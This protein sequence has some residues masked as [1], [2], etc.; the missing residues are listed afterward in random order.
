[1]SSQPFSALCGRPQSV[2]LSHMS[3][4]ARTWLIVVAGALL[5]TWVGIGVV[6]W[7]RGVL[8]DGHA[9]SAAG[10]PQEDH[11]PKPDKPSAPPWGK[12]ERIPITIAPPIEFVPEFTPLEKFEI[13][14]YFPN[15]SGSRLAELLAESGISEEVR[16][17]LMSMAALEPSISGY[18]IRP[19]EEFVYQL[20]RQDRARL[21]VLLAQFAENFYHVKAFRFCGKSL[22]DWL[23]GAPLSEETIALVRPLVFQHEGYLFFA[24][25]RVIEKRISS[26]DERLALIKALSRE[27]TFLARLRVD[28]NSDIE[29]LVNY[30]GRGG[31][32]KDVRP[33]L[34]SAASVPGGVSLAISHLLPPF[35]RQRL[36]TYPVP[37]ERAPAINQDCHW[38]AFNFFNTEP[39]NRFCDENEVVKALD[40]EYYRVFGN[41]QLGDIVMFFIEGNRVIHSAVYIADDI[42][43]TKNGS[44]ASRPWMLT[45]LE[46]MKGYY[47]TLKPKEIR[48]YRK[49]N[50]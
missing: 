29:G 5:A 26:A 48:Y 25:L 42:L 10:V 36:Y 24:D 39:D 20:S 6:L 17:Q 43:F 46:D 15:T 40:N 9:N 31:R 33:L 11:N 3:Y 28:Q 19:S 12:I 50:I 34:E 35:A 23:R 4:R 1:M 14:W 47:P 38:T 44:I 22:D 21:Y 2:V 30:W 49:K 27:A 13:V 45:T 41:L 8:G 37:P 18:A 32:A 16:K 7:Q